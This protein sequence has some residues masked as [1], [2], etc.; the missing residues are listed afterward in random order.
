MT[1]GKQPIT[2]N[3]F[4]FK[5]GNHSTTFKM[6]GLNRNEFYYI[7]KYLYEHGFKLYKNEGD[8][9]LFLNKT[10]DWGNEWRP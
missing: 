10:R 4:K 6:V 8:S 1:K 2:L 5:K 7:R 9:Y 3:R